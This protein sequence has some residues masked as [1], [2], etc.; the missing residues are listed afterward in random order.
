MNRRADT[1]DS[2]DADLVAADARARADALDP[3]RSFIVQAPAGSGKTE[4]LIQRYLRLLATVDE[5]EEVVAMTFTRKAAGEMRERVLCAL[6]DAERP[7]PKLPHALTTWKLARDL[8]AHSRRRGWELGDHAARLGI[9]T[10]DAW[11]MRLTRNA[12]LAAGTG[13]ITGVADDTSAL[14]VAAARSLVFQR[15]MSPSC[16]RLLAHLDNQADRLVELLAGM[17]AQRDQW[18]PWLIEMRKRPDELRSSVERNWRVIVDDI[19]ARA[20]RAVEPHLKPQCLAL[21]RYA[22]DNRIVAN[23]ALEAEWPALK[24]WPAATCDE[25]AAWRRLAELLLTKGGA[26]RKTV[27]TDAGF[28]APTSATG[29]EKLLRQTRKAEATALLD[30]LRQA[31]DECADAW[32]ALHRMPRFA[33]TD[34]QW[35]VVEALLAALPLAAAQLR[36]EFAQNNVTD[37]TELS[38]GALA[39]LG[40]ETTPS[41]V[42]LAYDSRVR[43]VLIDEFQDTSLTQFALLSRLT[44]GW[45]AGDGR[46]LFAVGDPMQSVYRFRGAE[47]GLFLD[48]R[49]AGIGEIRLEPLQLRVNFRSTEGLVE[50]VN[51]VFRQVLPDH[52]EPDAGLTP[53]VSA[54]TPSV[55]RALDWQVPVML[56]GVADEREQ[57]QR[58]VALVRAAQRERPEG[59]VAILVRTRN[60]LR[61]IIPALRDAGIAWQAI[62]IDPLAAKQPII[63]C[64]SL[65]HALLEPADRLA[66]LAVLRAP[67]CGLTLADLTR[68]TPSDPKAVLLERL[69]HADEWAALSEDG[70]ARL[71][72]CAPIL[73]AAVRR[74]SRGGLRGAAESAWLQLGGPATLRTGDDLD[75]VDRYWR[76]LAEH[77]KQPALDWSAFVAAIDALFGESPPPAPGV[78]PLQIMTMH[79]AKGLEFGTVIAPGLAQ[80]PGTSDPPL[81]RWRAGRT[82]TGAR[83]LLIAP[84]HGPGDVPDAQYEYLRRRAAAEERHELARLL[85]V[86]ATRAKHALHWVA[87]VDPEDVDD[88]VPRPDSSLGALWP[89]LGGEW[90]R[91]PAIEAAPAAASGGVP[92]QLLHRLPADWAPPP[93]TDIAAEERAPA[94]DDAPPADEPLLFDWVQDTARAVGIVAHDYLRRIADDG[95]GKW[96]AERLDRARGAIRAALAEEGVPSDELDDAHERVRRALATTL[97]SARGGWLFDAGHAEAHAEFALTCASPAGVQRIVLDR[98]FVATDGTRWIVDFKTSQHRGADLEGFLE[99]E[100]ERH[101]PQLENYARAVSALDPR[102]IRVGIYWPLHDAWREWSLATD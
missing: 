21:L 57:G 30:A 45:S 29:A 40:D 69:Q 87:V 61:E 68:L 33:Y 5:P 99:R 14:F 35:A 64:L 17:L 58:V 90:P 83:R 74:V 84:I 78:H 13:M 43:H 91:P 102:P 100:V 12:P 88:Y 11:C 70:R 52:E 7:A 80:Q 86:T 24:R 19:L 75:D 42:L 95:P 31:G 18:L 62:E 77:A 51:R 47:V 23:R 79:R 63:D 38:L 15:P 28:P 97:A 55:Q 9:Q 96:P 27:G 44:A 37:F 93:L 50:W 3:T 56:H 49:R 65:T 8:L 72:R 39:V 60:H 54:I 71:A 25:V 82:G 53:F 4:L 2:A 89:A 41:D 101:R 1:L 81:L 67:W 98:T 92:S 20:D 34:A 26:L 59:D 32:K 6:R 46:T 10:I 22:R 16:V 73:A 36:V 48:A 66:W 94:L 76:L 85:Y